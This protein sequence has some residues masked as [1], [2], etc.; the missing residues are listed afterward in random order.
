MNLLEY[1]IRRL[2]AMVGVILGVTLLTFTITRL[3][4]AD[5]VAIMMGE[6][7]HDPAQIAII[8]RQLGLDQPLP[9]QYVFY[10]GRLILGNWGVSYHTGLPVL[11][12]IQLYFGATFQLTLVTLALALV[13]GIPLG[14]ISALK[15]DKWADHITRIT[16]LSGIA[17]PIF[18]LALMMQ[19]VFYSWLGIL[20]YGGIVDDSLLYEH[21]VTTITGLIFIDTLLTGNWVV[22]LN[23]LKHIILPAAALGFRAVAWIMRMTRSSMIEVLRQDHIRT[24]RAW[25]LPE[26]IVIY[27]R[28]LKNSLIPILTTIGLTYGLLLQGSFLTEAIFN[29]PGMGLYAVNSIIYSDYP[30]ILGVSLT[31]ALVYVTVNLVIDI[32]Y[33]Y[34]D[35]RIRY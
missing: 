23:A 9:V 25:G 30:S 26:R 34:A 21:P 4:P 31:A 32:L 1:T 33:C 3:I 27:K 18:W 2:I 35:P 17:I 19:L 16:A 29:W 15:K 24:A 10:L 7:Y 20:P 5:P 6:G 11:Q 8:R 28:A 22:F 14:V 13:L 12:D